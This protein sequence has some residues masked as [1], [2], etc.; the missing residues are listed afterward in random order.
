MLGSSPHGPGLAWDAPHPQCGNRGLGGRQEK[1]E[2]SGRDSGR[3]TSVL[4]DVFAV[5]SIGSGEP[6]P[7]RAA[8]DPFEASQ[9][10]CFC[11]TPLSA[12]GDRGD[13]GEGTRRWRVSCGRAKARP[14]DG[15]VPGRRRRWHFVFSLSNHLN[16]IVMIV[17]I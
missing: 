14:L 8:P 16:F 17:F 2:A 4:V 10:L 6:F 11:P 5:L 15:S 9:R 13:T 7:S 3:D 12:R 1:T